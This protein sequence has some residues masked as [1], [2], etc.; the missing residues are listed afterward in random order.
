MSI[1]IHRQAE[2]LMGRADIAHM[3]GDL[4]EEQELSLQA[5][6][7][8]EDVFNGTPEV[9][10]RTR[11][12]IGSSAVRLYSRARAFSDV[13]RAGAEILGKISP[14]QKWAHTEITKMVAEA[15][16]SLGSE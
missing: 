6:R 8:E 15:K 9:R 2:E 13:L 11:A 14:Q 1:E 5:A 4:T 12:I 16:K 7:L 10:R 3:R